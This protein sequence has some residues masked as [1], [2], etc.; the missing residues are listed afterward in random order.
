VR[1]SLLG[2]GAQEKILKCLKE[3]L[4]IFSK[5]N[6]SL[7][8]SATR[9]FS[10]NN[11]LQFFNARLFNATTIQPFFRRIGLINNNIFQVERALNSV[12]HVAF[13]GIVSRD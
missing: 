7:D 12:E 6:V 4:E 11:K 2:I 5:F 1:L 13:K 9:L 10:S 8:G 3:K